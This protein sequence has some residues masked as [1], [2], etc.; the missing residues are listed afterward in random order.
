MDE[1]SKKKKVLTP[2]AALKKA[3]SYCAYQERAQQEIRD[4][5][6]DWGLHMEDVEQTI[7]KLIES[8]FLN[9]ERFAKAYV[10]GKFRMQGWGKIKIVQQL[11]L[12]R[13]SK[14]LIQIALREIDLD[15]YEAKL[16]GIIE[17]KIDKPIAKLSYQERS[18]LVR[19]LMGKGYETDLIFR[20][21]GHR[22]DIDG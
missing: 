14:P 7:S 5:L 15:D 2:L 8:N 1:A 16:T 9:E 4:K 11:K 13:I 20:L 19:F 6:Y 18:K 21:L 17:K 12:K 3:E 10:L 22:A